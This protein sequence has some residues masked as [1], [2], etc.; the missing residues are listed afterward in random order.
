[1]LRIEE[2]KKKYEPLE[3]QG[4]QMENWHRRNGTL[5]LGF[6]RTESSCSFQILTLTDSLHQSKTFSF[7]WRTYVKPLLPGFSSFTCR[8]NLIVCE[9]HCGL[10]WLSGYCVWVAC[11]VFWVAVQ[12][13]IIINSG[14][15][16]LWSVFNWNCKS[17][18]LH[19][20]WTYQSLKT[21]AAA[22]RAK[23]H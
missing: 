5:P 3:I 23:M 2:K 4:I 16:F 10:Y 20:I 11:V 14:S 8:P 19:V 1:M 15:V 12:E 18:P 7:L 6:F 17:S 22:A 13:L 9:L 21:A